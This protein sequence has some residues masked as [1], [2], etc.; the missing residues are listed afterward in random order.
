MK[1][2]PVLY[3]D[4]KVYT[5]SAFNRGV[6]RFLGRLPAVW[7]EG[8]IQELRRN[9]AWASVFLTLKDPKTGATLKVTIART[10]FD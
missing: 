5:V 7:V 4:R 8:E 3:G 10:T 9:P 1:V 2:E 6:S